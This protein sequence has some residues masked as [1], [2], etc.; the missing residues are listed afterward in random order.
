MNNFASVGSI[1]SP[2]NQ[3]FNQPQRQQQQQQQSQRRNQYVRP[4]QADKRAISPQQQRMIMMQRQEQQR[5][6]QQQGQ[7]QQQQQ[8]R[9]Q[10]QQPS[11]QQNRQMSYNRMPQMQQADPQQMDQRYEQQMQQRGQYNRQQESQRPNNNPYNMQH[12]PVQVPH[13]QMPNT[14]QQQA[15][16][17]QQS[18]NNIVFYSRTCRYSKMFIEKLAE[19][20]F[21]NTFNKLCIDVDKYGKRPPFPRGINQVPSIIIGDKVYQGKNAFKWLN[22]YLPDD[23]EKVDL[24]EYAPNEMGNISDTYSR[25]G[26]NDSAKEGGSSQQQ[27]FGVFGD[28]H[29]FINTVTDN[30]PKNNRVGDGEMATF[31]AR[32]A[33]QDKELGLAREPPREINFEENVSQ[34]NNNMEDIYNTQMDNRSNE[35][36]NRQQQMNAPNFTSPEYIAE[37]GSQRGGTFKGNRNDYYQPLNESG[38]EQL[39]QLKNTQNIPRHAKPRR[40]PDF[41]NNLYTKKI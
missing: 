21:K 12:N 38:Y 5:R 31:E 40:T 15:V 3:Q 37:A 26:D 9:P 34:N 16:E 35:I 27:S 19:T 32:R 36:S 17:D 7:P 13:R 41:N 24:S 30:E 10:L 23:V 33:M 18:N 4:G 8:Y 22:E 2:L 6:N 39:N 20:H 29:K 28:S 14:H 11:Q 1:G 25:I